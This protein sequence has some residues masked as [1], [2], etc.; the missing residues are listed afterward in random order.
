MVNEA[1]TVE[2]QFPEFCARKAAKAEIIREHHIT[3]LVARG[4]DGLPRENVMQ[5]SR[6]DLKI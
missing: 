4:K 1:A 5:K 3:P 6:Q 2:R